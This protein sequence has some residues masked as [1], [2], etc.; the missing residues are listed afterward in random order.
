MFIKFFRLLTYYMT[1]CWFFEVP[2]D[3]CKY[4][5]ISP[6]TQWLLYKGSQYLIFKN[7]K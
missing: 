6:N 3:I 5:Q 4:K 1:R 2:F 7:Q